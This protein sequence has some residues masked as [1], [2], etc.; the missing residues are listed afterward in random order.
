[1]G[2]E[3]GETWR[4]WT[5]QNRRQTPTAWTGWRR[6][7]RLVVQR[8]AIKEI[9]EQRLADSSSS[10][11][12]DDEQR[13]G[14]PG[15]GGDEPAGRTPAGTNHDSGVDGHPA[16]SHGENCGSGET[17]AP[18][19]LSWEGTCLEEQ[20]LEVE[21]P[22]NVLIR[23]EDSYYSNDYFDVAAYVN[24]RFY[25]LLLTG[26]DLLV[27][28]RVQIRSRARARRRHLAIYY[29]DIGA[30]LLRTLL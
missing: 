6:G 14:P 28:D 3:S 2:E 17:V 5:N 19:K 27:F 25:W 7:R 9:V 1:M 20:N 16:A 4:R 26:L 12:G 29:E 23:D 13:H 18:T 21:T 15:S 24:L 8:L 22:L 30:A 10:E 11:T